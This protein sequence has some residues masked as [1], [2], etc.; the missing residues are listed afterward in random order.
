VA[1]GLLFDPQ[2]AARALAA[3]VGSTLSMAI[4]RA[5]PTFTGQASDPPVRGEFKVRAVSGG[6]VTLKGRM[7][8][9]MTL[10]LGPCACLEIEGILVAV[11]S[12]KSQML[13]RELFRMV[14]I[15]PEAMKILVV[16]SSNHFRADFTPIAADIIVAKAAGPMAADPGDLPWKRLSAGTRSRP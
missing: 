3:G 8:T 13:D 15:T 12:G 4:G 11:A 14:G 10:H 9:G 6:T 7:L 5:V 2:A 1:L 16:K